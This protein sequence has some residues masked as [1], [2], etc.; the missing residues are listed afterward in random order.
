MCAGGFAPR[1][2]RHAHAVELAREAVALVVI[3]RMLGHSNLGITCVHPHRL[4]H[5]EII[6]IVHP[7]ARR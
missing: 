2:L 1:Q 6:D 3:Q 4:D 7:A 5:A